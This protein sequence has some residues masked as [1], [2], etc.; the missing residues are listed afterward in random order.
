MFE[1]MVQAQGGHYEGSDKGTDRI[2]LCGPRSGETGTQAVVTQSSFGI[3][4]PAVHLQGRTLGAPGAF[5][6]AAPR[7]FSTVVRRSIRES[8]P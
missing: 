3:G 8:M 2:H 1:T 5:L 7:L 6:R 4:H